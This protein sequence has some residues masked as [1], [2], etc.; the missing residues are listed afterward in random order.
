[1]NRQ[2]HNRWTRSPHY[3]R[4]I[5]SWPT[6]QQ[7]SYSFQLPRIYITS[8]FP[9][10]TCNN[11]MMH[12]PFVCFN[13]IYYHYSMSLFQM[14]ILSIFPLFALIKI[15]SIFA[16]FALEIMSIFPLFALNINNINIA[17][18]CLK[19]ICHQ[20]FLCPR[21]IDIIIINIASICV[22]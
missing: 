14:N 4:I 16:L 18:V 7:Y 12:I 2:L 1:M 22:E 5:Y 3:Q 15:V 20:Y 9:L 8:T 19:Q 17:S 21:C 13:S 6:K 11:N 10:L